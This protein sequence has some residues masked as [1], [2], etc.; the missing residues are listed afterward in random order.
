MAN[1]EEEYLD[2]LQNIEGAIVAVYRQNPELTDYDVD[3]VTSTLIRLYGS[4]GQG[5]AFHLPAFSAA[6]SPLF[7]AV[8]I[9]CDVW[10]GRAAL[11]SQKNRQDFKIPRSLTTQEIIACLKRI[12]KSLELW[13]KEGGRQGYLNYVSQFIP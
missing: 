3:K 4:E 7:E 2:V 10:L 11:K 13:T 8:K 6:A 5:K 9:T 1:V 12:R